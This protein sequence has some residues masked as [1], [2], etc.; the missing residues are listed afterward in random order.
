MARSHLSSAIQRF[1]VLAVTVNH[2]LLSVTKSAFWA[3]LHK[4]HMSAILVL[5]TV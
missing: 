4:I 2:S 1:T 3:I 5:E